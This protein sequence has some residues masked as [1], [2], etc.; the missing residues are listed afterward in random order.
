MDLSWPFHSRA[1]VSSALDHLSSALRP[2]NDG[3][4]ELAVGRRMRAGHLSHG[5]SS[6]DLV[7]TPN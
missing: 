4:T 7:V 5:T 3:H 6:V 2:K 1:F